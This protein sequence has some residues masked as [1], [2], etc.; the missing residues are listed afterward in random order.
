[1]LVRKII[2]PVLILLIS[3]FLSSQCFKD[4]QLQNG[5]VRNAY[6]EKES[7]ILNMLQSKGLDINAMEIFIR[8]FKKEKKLEVWG[9][10]SLHKEFVFLKEYRICRTSGQEGPKRKQ[11][12]G[13]IPEGF[14]TI[15]RFNPW[16]QFHLSLGL[17]YPNRSDKILSDKK[18]PGGDIFIHGSCVTIGCL[19][20]TNDK[21]KEIYILAV[22]AKNNGQQY[23]P[24]HVFPVKMDG[25]IYL[26][27]IEKYA[28]DED[29]LEFWRNLEEGYLYFEMNRIVPE[30][31]VNEEGIHCF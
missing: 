13:Q 10:D 5:R 21:I 1:M 15:D 16:S 26:E 8:A 18:H 30:F 24:V 3:N 14:Y 7:V 2:F 29:L 17:N 12:D 25:D 27:L 4:Q 9:R 23:I 19:P 20:M 6:K 31:T 28:G 22:E 11:G